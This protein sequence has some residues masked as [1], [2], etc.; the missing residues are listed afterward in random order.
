MPAALWATLLAVAT[1]VGG[2]AAVMT[3]FPRIT[4]VA[5]AGPIDQSNPASIAFTI[6]NSNVYPLED[7]GVTLAVCELSGEKAPFGEMAPYGQV[8]C[9]IVAYCVVPGDPR[10]GILP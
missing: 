4:V 2:L 10:C 5:A 3:F 8:R 9:D 6:T 7:V 1:L